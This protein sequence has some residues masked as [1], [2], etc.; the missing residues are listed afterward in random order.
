MAY[1][2]VVVDGR[3]A[4]VYVDFAFAERFEGLQSAGHCVIDLERQ[5]SPPAIV[6][7]EPAVYGS[8]PN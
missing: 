8:D 6:D 7:L 2:A 3:P 1:V 5:A 4:N